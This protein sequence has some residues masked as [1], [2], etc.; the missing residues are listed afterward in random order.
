MKN[1]TI[2]KIVHAHKNQMGKS[3]I[4]QPLPKHELQD[5]DPFVHLV[6]HGP[7]TYEK[8]EKPLT[9]DAHPHR[10][11]EPVTF[12]FQGEL[13]HRD[14]LGNNSVIKAG[15][16]QW[17]TAGSGIVHAEG[18][19]QQFINHGGT[20]EMIQLWINLPARLKMTSPNYQGFQHK[21][22]PQ[23]KAS[24]WKADLNIISGDWGGVKGP[25]NS[26]SGIRTATIELTKLGET[27]LQTRPTNAA[28]LYIVK[29]K[30]TVN[31]T[32][33]QTHD[34]IAFGHEGEKLSINAKEPTVALFMAGEPN[35]EPIVRQGPYVMNSK[36]EIYDATQDYLA[37]KMGTMAQ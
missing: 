14:S 27:T 15:G 18:A 28:G 22:I 16:V 21:E 5:L 31:E 4:W 2:D 3:T 12:I 19:T 1:R 26:I 35:E 23:V 20:V 30:A 13:F 6:H 34:F 29:G 7:D 33:V 8:G 11:F 17:I 10:G 36:R 32:I 25:V 37:G 24:D 9:F